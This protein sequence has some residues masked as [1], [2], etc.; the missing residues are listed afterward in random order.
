MH[1]PT[2]GKWRDVYI[3]RGKLPGTLFIR[4]IVQFELEAETRVSV[5]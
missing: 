1:E 4:K 5:V 3:E 2:I